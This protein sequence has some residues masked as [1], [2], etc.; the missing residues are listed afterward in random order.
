VL[1][2]ERATTEKPDQDTTAADQDGPVTGDGRPRGPD[3]KVFQF[4]GGLA[5]HR[6]K[7]PWTSAQ[8]WM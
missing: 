4:P 1:N 7:S 8:N 5:R 6:T 3:Q 2:A